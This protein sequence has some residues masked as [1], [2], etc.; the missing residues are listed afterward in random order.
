MSG[1]QLLSL[2]IMG[3]KSH[4]RNTTARRMTALAPATPHILAVTTQQPRAWQH[5][6]TI[7]TK[8]TTE[9]SGI[10]ELIVSSVS[11]QIYVCLLPAA[12]K[13]WPR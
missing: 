7:L 9:D 12:T 10:L 8:K 5:D 1:L 6:V 13:L 3:W 11:N 4:W 2:V